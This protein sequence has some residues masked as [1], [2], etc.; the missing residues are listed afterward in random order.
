MRLETYL[1]TP[2]L[3][4][5]SQ[6][7]R[8]AVYR[9]THKRLMRGDSAYRQRFNSY[10][11]G[12]ICLGVIPGSLVFG[13]SGALALSLSVLVSFA[14]VGAL[15]CLAFRQQRFMNQRIGDELERKA[16]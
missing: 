15:I 11:S 8:F 10:L 7:E 14:A 6:G 4:R 12:V 9:A 2:G 3:D 1:A 16:S 13:G 5:Y